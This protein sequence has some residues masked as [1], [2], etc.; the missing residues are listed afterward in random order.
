MH[1]MMVAQS[2]FG[3]I[4]TEAEKHNAKQ[5][6]EKISC[7][8]SCKIVVLST[9]EGDDKPAKYPTIFAKSKVLL[10]NK[11]DLLD[12]PGMVD[13]DIEKVKADA[14]KL[15]SDIKIFAVS[16]RTGKGMNE[17]YDWLIKS[18]ADVQ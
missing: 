13:F 3:L 6:K 7:G 8:E 12:T 16:A 1:E 11:I 15:N 4:S 14:V 5:K 17:W 18:V 2:L 9:A 10:I